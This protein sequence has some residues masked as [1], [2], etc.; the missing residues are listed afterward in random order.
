MSIFAHCSEQLW[1]HKGH[2]RSTP[3]AFHGIH[4]NSLRS[5]Y[6]CGSGF[7]DSPVVGG[8]HH[9][10]EATMSL[11]RFLQQ[12][13]SSLST[14][15]HP[16]GLPKCFSNHPAT[17]GYNRLVANEGKAIKWDYIH[18]INI[19]K[20]NSLPVLVWVQSF[21]QWKVKPVTKCPVKI[22]A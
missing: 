1:G 4:K 20:L 3:H 7:V 14:A 13:A 2:F 11:M 17:E 5:T 16:C 6:E 22:N 15:G 12:K 19:C 10:V 9:S 21:Q 8:Y 18:T